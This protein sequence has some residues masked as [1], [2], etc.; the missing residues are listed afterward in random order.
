MDE[1]TKALVASNLVVAIAM[2]RIGKTERH[3]A[4]G[5][6]RSVLSGAEL[7][8][9]AVDDFRGIYELLSKSEK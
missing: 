2:Q 4:T 1:N 7:W 5:E 6:V 8:R 3:P 9:E